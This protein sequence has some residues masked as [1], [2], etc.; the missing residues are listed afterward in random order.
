MNT[1]DCLLVHLVYCALCQCTASLEKS[2]HFTIVLDITKCDIK[3][4]ML[5]I[6]ESISFKDYIEFS[7]QLSIFPD[8]SAYSPRDL[9]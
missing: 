1:S 5:G 6:N 7:F 4:Q 9:L 8:V 2:L 3:D